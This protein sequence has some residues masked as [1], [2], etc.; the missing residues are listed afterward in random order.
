[1]YTEQNS[2]NRSAAGVSMCFQRL[3]RSVQIR[4]KQPIAPAASGRI[5]RLIAFG[6]PA[7]QGWHQRA[8]LRKQRAVNELLL[9]FFRGPPLK[10]TEWVQEWPCDEPFLPEAGAYA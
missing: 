5:A 3:V 10:P 6:F 1:M 2:V 9:Q 7:L 8:L 4:L